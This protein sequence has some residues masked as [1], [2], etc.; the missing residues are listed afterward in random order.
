MV[1]SSRVVDPTGISFDNSMVEYQMF[2]MDN[3]VPKI[4]RIMLIRSN[5][6]R[7]SDP[8]LI[9]GRIGFF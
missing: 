9:A 5:N 7:I 8:N 3:L 6:V 4:I 1:T 2:G